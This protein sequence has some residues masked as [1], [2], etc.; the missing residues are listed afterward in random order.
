MITQR[1]SLTFEELYVDPTIEDD[2]VLK[3]KICKKGSSQSLECRF[4]FRRGIF[5]EQFHGKVQLQF[6]FDYEFL[7]KVHDGPPFYHIA[8]FLMLSDEN[9]YGSWFSPEKFLFDHWNELYASDV[10]GEI[11]DFL[12]YKVHYIGKATEEH[13]IK[14]LTGHE[15][16][17]DILSIEHPLHYGSLPTD[18]IAI[19]FYEFSDNIH[20]AMF[21]QDDDISEMFQQMVDGNLPVIPKKRIYL[22][23]E[24]ALIHALKPK[25]NKLFYKN[26]P[27]SKDGLKQELLDVFTYTFFDPITLVY[28]EGEITGSDHFIEADMLLVKKGEALKIY[29]HSNK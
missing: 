15:H 28:A 21:S 19:L 5:K 25:H 10:Q 23:A 17:Q 27:Q 4:P 26:Y 9:G 8:N 3:F 6:M 14:R 18:E 7:N 16:L 24:K 11:S 29:K 22:D 20:L 12:K 1:P 2:P 13:V